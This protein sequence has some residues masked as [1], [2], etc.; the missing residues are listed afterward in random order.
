[1]W[2]LKG[3]LGPT[4]SWWLR[5]SP[6]LH[7]PSQAWRTHLCAVITDNITDKRVCPAALRADASRLLG[8]CFLLWNFHDGA[9]SMFTRTPSS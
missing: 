8:P 9:C 6:S 1:M 3:T 2:E 7:C 5:M 4:G